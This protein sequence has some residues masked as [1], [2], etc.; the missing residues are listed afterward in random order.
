MFMAEH[1]RKCPSLE[2]LSDGYIDAAKG[3]QDP[4]GQDYV[5]DCAGGSNEPDVHSLGPDGDSG[6]PIRCEKEKSGE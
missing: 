3:T 4:W 2:D 1:P 6:Q 5:V